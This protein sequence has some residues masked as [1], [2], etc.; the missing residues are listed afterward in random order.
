MKHSCA[1]R[2]ST[3]CRDAGMAPL[4]AFEVMKIRKLLYQMPLK[5]L[6][7]QFPPYSFC[8]DHYK[9]GEGVAAIQDFVLVFPSK[10]ILF[11][12]CRAET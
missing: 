1:Y 4:R 7:T 3:G 6:S 5:S 9:N 8:S 2:Q 11:F 10:N 12:S